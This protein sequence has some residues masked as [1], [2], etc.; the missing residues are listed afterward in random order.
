LGVLLVGYH[1]LSYDEAQKMRGILLWLQREAPWA[2]IRNTSGKI[3]NEL[4]RAR[5]QA[6]FY[7]LIITDKESELFRDV[8]RW[9]KEKEQFEGG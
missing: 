4:K 6:E 9:A 5:P 7:Q 8:Q 3:A 2:E 1:I